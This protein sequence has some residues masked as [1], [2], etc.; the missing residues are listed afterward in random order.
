MELP[1]DPLY[2]IQIKRIHEYKRQYLNILS[3]IYRYHAIKSASP[4]ERAKMVRRKPSTFSSR[5]KAIGTDGLPSHPS[6]A[7][8]RQPCPGWK[9]L[10]T[11]WCHGRHKGCYI[12][13]RSVDWVSVAGWQVPRVCL[14]GGKAASAYYMAKKIVRLINSVGTVVNADPDVGDLLKVGL[15]LQILMYICLESQGLNGLVSKWGFR[16]S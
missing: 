15:P 2:D 4:A 13:L 10:W 14:F 3:L 11:T 9:G 16:L 1:S 6:I 7:Y 12:P 5:L 8:T